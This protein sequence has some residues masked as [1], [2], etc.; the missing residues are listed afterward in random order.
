VG[1]LRQNTFSYEAQH[2]GGGQ[3]GRREDDV[4]GHWWSRRFLFQSY[5]CA[6]KADFNI[7]SKDTRGEIKTLS[8][9]WSY[10]YRKNHRGRKL[11]RGEY[12]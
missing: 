5:G 12:Y 1:V 9:I 6:A 7:T 2:L 8:T 3:K 10:I 4:T 11:Y